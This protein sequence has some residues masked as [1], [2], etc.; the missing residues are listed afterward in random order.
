MSERAETALH[1]D[2]ID[3]ADLKQIHRIMWGNGNYVRIAD[4]VASACTQLVAELGAGPGVDWLDVACGTG[5]VSIPAAAAGARVVGID[6]TPEHF[7][8]ARARAKEAG[9]VVDWSQGDAEQL[10]LA[11]ATFDRVTSTFGSQ[12]AP[13]HDRVAA[14]LVRVCRPGGLIGLCNW[15]ADG[16]T[17]RFQSILASYFP[18]PQ[19]YQRPAMAWGDPAYVES[20]FADHP[21]S[22]SCTPRTVPY[23]FP[24]ADHLVRFFERHFGPFITA[25]QAVSPRSRWGELRD[26]LVA[27]TESMDSGETDHLLVDVDYLVVVARRHPTED[28]AI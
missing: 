22:V 20:L 10:D 15:T 18:D 2:A 19:E 12:F 5:N 8:V 25:R 28:M 3:D 26:D 4:L 9:V 24:S 17:G 6:L 27:M 16:W 14:E 21:V 23:E 7:P 1:P 13:R 11:D